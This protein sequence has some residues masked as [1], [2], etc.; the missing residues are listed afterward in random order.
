MK[1]HLPKSS[2]PSSAS[3][4]YEDTQ[5]RQAINDSGVSSLI[6]RGENGELRIGIRRAVRQQNSVTSSSLL[7][8]HSMHLGVLAAAA[9]AV[10][11]KTMLTIF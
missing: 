2:V 4:D 9:H 7:S 3:G 5:A 10:S 8:S 11:T 6:L 1:S